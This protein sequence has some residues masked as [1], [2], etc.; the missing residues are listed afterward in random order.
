MV[1][2]II[3]ITSYTIEVTR[4]SNN[5]SVI[6]RRDDEKLKLDQSLRGG[7]EEEIS[8]MEAAQEPATVLVNEKQ[9][10]EV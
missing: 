7:K 8:T 4:W 3:I 6:S 2:L 9:F 5:K 1:F 10:I